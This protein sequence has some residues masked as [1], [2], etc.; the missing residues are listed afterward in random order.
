MKTKDALITTLLIGGAV[1]AGLSLAKAAPI[2]TSVETDL[3]K[4]RSPGHYWSLQSRDDG[5]GKVCV[6][7]ITAPSRLG[8]AKVSALMGKGQLAFVVTS[9]DLP[10]ATRHQTTARVTLGAN[11]KLK[12]VFTAHGASI[13]LNYSGSITI[14]SAMPGVLEAIEQAHYAKFKFSDASIGLTLDGLRPMMSDLKRCN[15]NE[16]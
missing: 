1:L 13:R 2:G 10:L 9:Y 6:A 14:S 8:L 7:R 12:G 16:I 15:R 3:N 4:F 5:D 11:P